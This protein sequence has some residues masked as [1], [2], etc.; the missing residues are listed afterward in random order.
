MKRW[1]YQHENNVIEVTYKQSGGSEL[2]VNGDV[3]DNCSDIYS[4]S[5]HR[6]RGKLINGEEIKA[7]I[8]GIFRIKCS[9]Y[10]N[11]KLLNPLP[12]IV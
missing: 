6:L 4:T 2:I 11:H 3:Q 7:T 8:G 5:D 10:V 9:L 1:S 12:K